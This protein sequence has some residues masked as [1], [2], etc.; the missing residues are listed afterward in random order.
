[1]LDP[2]GILTCGIRTH[3]EPHQH[4]RKNHMLLV[5]RLRRRHPGLR[6]RDVAIVIH[7]DHALFTQMLHRHGNRRLRKSEQICDIDGTHHLLAHRQHQ[8]TLQ[9]ILR[10]LMCRIRTHIETPFQ[11]LEDFIMYPR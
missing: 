7:R 1:M 4:I 3:P 11:K 10:R 2:A 8:N 5:G 9:I 6:Q